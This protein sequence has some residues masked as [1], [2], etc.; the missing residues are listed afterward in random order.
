MYKSRFRTEPTNMTAPQWQAALWGSLE[1]L[2]EEMADCCIK[3]YTLERV[4]TVKKDMVTGVGFL[5]EAMKVLENKPSTS[6]WA[7]L[8]QSL[9]KQVKDAA[10]S[11]CNVFR[12][13]LWY[14]TSTFRLDIFTADSERGISSP[15]SP[16]PF[17][18]CQDRGTYR[19]GVQSNAAKVFLLMWFLPPQD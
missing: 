16:L 17:V 13:R 5:D 19:H 11:Q 14:L 10:K 8:G 4:L 3:V 2:V 1:S 7:A 15:S 6:F 18:L 12:L 9:E